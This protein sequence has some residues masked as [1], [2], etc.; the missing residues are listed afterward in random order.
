MNV[1]ARAKFWIGLVAVFYLFPLSVSA[2]EEKSF[3][4]T[5]DSRV[6]AESD[7]NA[8]AGDIAIAESGFGIEHEY[9][10]GGALPL[11]LSF[12][13]KHTDINENLPVNLPSHLEG[14]SFGIGTKFPMP[15]CA[16][17]S[18]FMGIDVFPSWYTDDWTW[19]DSA[20][21]MPFRIYGI[22][23]KSD[24]F[25]V[26][27]GASIRV[28]YDESVLPILGIIYK[29]N[30][31]L[32]FNLASDDPNVTYQWNEHWSVF[33][34]L[35]FVRDEY[36]VTRGGQKG[37]VLKYRETSGGVGLRYHHDKLLQASLSV[38]SVMG[39]RLQYRDDIGKVEPDAGVYARA[40]LRVL[41]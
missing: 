41:F 27:A 8:M 15:F 21:R 5:A 37:V 34:E 17:D 31:R 3:T 33:G 9:K 23:K 35:D 16:S 18:H 11:G 20:F 40:K 13:Y 10:I 14:R 32:S 24:A 39:R 29:P 1:S 22:Y 6:I 12:D 30:D 36:E 7:V 38:G 4:I 2:G 28:D 25:I 19:T 26:V